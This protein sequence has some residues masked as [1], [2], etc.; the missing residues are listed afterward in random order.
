MR[1]DILKLLEG[2]NTVK[3]SAPV[4][5]ICGPDQIQFP[6]S[7]MGCSISTHST[8]KKAKKRS[9][10]IRIPVVNK[11]PP[12]KPKKVV[13]YGDPQEAEFKSN[14]LVLDDYQYI[15]RLGQGGT[16]H[17]VEVMKDSEKYA[18]K[19][20]N[21][22]DNA[23]NFIDIP[24]RNPKDEAAILLRLS[25]PYVVK[26][27]DLIENS[28]DQIYI[29]MELCEEGD[30]T[31]CRPDELKPIFAQ[32]LSAVEYLHAQ[33]VAHRDIKPSN[34]MRHRDG[35]IRLVD[36]G[37]AILVPGTRKSIRNEF[38]GTPAYFAPEIY[39]DSSYDPFASDI[40]AL[41]TTLYQMAFGVLPF[42]ANRLEDLARNVRQA[43]LEF[44]QTADPE[45]VDLLECMLKRSPKDRITIKE[46]WKHP[47][48]H[49][50]RRLS[51]SN[52]APVIY[53]RLS[54]RERQ[55]SIRHVSNFNMTL[56]RM[57]RF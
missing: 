28:K 29:V 3:I 51:A 36:F 24:T 57:P 20:C 48:M 54:L 18:M 15:G 42:A 46:I 26:I 47:W 14:E 39:S 7:P 35:N 44:P 49:T 4:T 37:N 25:H 55:A 31:H 5:M 22:E 40:W 32:I 19:I 6:K 43:P 8:K 33:R 16:S 9:V 17:V 2:P 13:F 34:I 52:R 1:N 41:G 11:P 10:H 21:I 53:K 38:M 12:E 50:Y 27:Y 23:P 30:V 56:P 45:L